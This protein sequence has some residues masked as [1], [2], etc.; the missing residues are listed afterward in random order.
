M[1]K[2]FNMALIRCPVGLSEEIVAVFWMKKS[3]IDTEIDKLE[4]IQFLTVLCIFPKFL[5]KFVD[6]NIEKCQQGTI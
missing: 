5:T 6:C 4:N 3:Q 2:K 1:L